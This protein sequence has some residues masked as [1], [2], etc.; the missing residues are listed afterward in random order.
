MAIYDR[1]QELSV[2]RSF[3]PLRLSLKGE[4][5]QKNHLTE[6][7]A[8]FLLNSIPPAVTILKNMSI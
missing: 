1:M 7:D 5:L 4:Q 6:F 8:L 3:L 2:R